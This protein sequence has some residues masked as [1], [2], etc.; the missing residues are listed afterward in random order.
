MSTPATMA[1]EIEL[2]EQLAALGMG[3]AQRL[4]DAAQTTDDQDA[5]A[6]IGMAFHHISRGV[7]QSLALKARFTAGWVPTARA[8]EP[9][10]IAAPPPPAP[11]RERTESTGWNEY[12]RLDSEELLDE[13]D[14]LADAPE[15]EPID[16]ERLEAALEAGVARLQRGVLA[17][18]PK[19]K[20]AAV[21]RPASRA[22]LLNG[23]MRLQVV[24]SS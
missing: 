13:L 18:R 1:K 23:A 15:D 16:L 17:L 24:N 7:R 20:L 19:P 4:H 9:A 5:L 22:D 21:S 12:E 8:A 2:L 3:M 6:R 14:R 10:P 11:T